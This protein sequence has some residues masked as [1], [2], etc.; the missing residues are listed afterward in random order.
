MRFALLCIALLCVIGQSELAVAQTTPIELVQRAVAAQGGAEALR[1]VKTLVIRGEGK[2]WVT[3]QAYKAVGEPRFVGESIFTVTADLASR[4][5]RVDW[6]RELR[7]PTPSRGK[8]SELVFPTFGVV[9]QGEQARPMSGIRVATH[10]REHGRASPLLLLKAAAAPQNLAAMPDQKLGARSLPAVS[11]KDGGTT[12]IILF[13]RETHL[14][15][16]VRTRDDDHLFGDSDYD[17]VLADWKPVGGVKIAHSLS[18]RINGTEVQQLRYKDVTL[19]APIAAATFAVSDEVKAK[20]K[21]PATTNVPYQWVIGRLMLGRFVDSDAIYYA[22]GGSF[23]LTEL[24][25]NVQHVV[26]GSANDLI[27][28]MKDGIVIFDAPVDEGQSRWVMDAA[29]AKYPGKPIKYLVLTHHH[30]DHSGGMRAYVAEG[31][32]VIVP[33]QSRAFFEQVVRGPRSIAPDSLQRKMRP[34]R[35][36]EVKDSMSLKDDTIEINLHNIANPH[37][38]GFLIAHL[39]KEN[40]VWIT[41]LVS[42]RPHM[43]RTSWSVAAG[44]G[45]RKHGITGALIAGGHGTTGKQAD[46]AAI[47]N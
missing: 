11:V 19:N 39:V 13:D 9:V 8:F 14:P 26:G 2:Q 1:A 5:V 30:N 47:L 35:F 15:A 28:A 23:K 36:E 41:D 10:H 7:L 42:P 4:A 17:L 46:M 45:L 6:D 3:G 18:F 29:K 33:S 12:Y 37:A 25:P 22:P 16:A 43:V 24:A 32:T 21:P 27:V 31:V 44:E 34:A 20:A 40:I 38:D